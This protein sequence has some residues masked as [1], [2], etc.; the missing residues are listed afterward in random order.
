MANTVDLT[1][2]SEYIKQNENQLFVEST[3]GAKSL[4]YVELMLS[5]KYKEALNYLSSE[6]V[7]QAAS[8]GWDPNGSDTFFQRYIEVH[9][10]EVEKEYCLYDFRRT[11]AGLQQL[12]EAGRLDLPWQEKIAQSNVEAIKAAVEEMVWQGN[13]GASVTG[14]LADAAEASAVTVTFASGDTA[15]EKID[16]MVAA[17]TPKM[18]K[19][20]TILFV[21]YSDFMQYVRELNA[22][23]CASR[24]I[25]DSNT[26]ALDYLG[27]SAVKIVPVMGLEGTGKMVADSKSLVYGTD[28]EGSET[29]YKWLTDEREDKALFKVIFL[30]G[31]AIK[32]P[33]RLIVGGAAE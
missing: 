2:M 9:P 11:V 4:D 7:L 8:C 5:V 25:I 12:F 13:S 10:I 30:A 31:T 18:V 21:S 17:L 22:T 6:V 29:A 27:N 28:L 3:I 1:A 19:E 33:D 23:C 20:G 26:E 16:S 32:F 24:G 14:W 15:V